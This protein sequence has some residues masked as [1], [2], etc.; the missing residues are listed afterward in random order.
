MLAFIDITEV[1]ISP[2]IAVR[3]RVT[4]PTGDRALTQRTSP[5]SSGT[6]RTCLQTHQISGIL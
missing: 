2:V 6:L 5:E 1:F 3:L 4:P